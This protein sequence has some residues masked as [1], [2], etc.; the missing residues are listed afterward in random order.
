MKLHV[1]F[2][3]MLKEF[4]GRASDTL[5]VAEGARVADVLK[6][7]ESRI[8]RLTDMLPSLAVAVNQQYAGPQTV[9]KSEDEIALL[10]PVSG[11]TE[12]PGGSPPDGGV[13]GPMVRGDAGG[14]RRASIVWSRIDSESVSQAL[15][16]GEDGAAVVFEGTARNQTRGRKTLY[17][18]YEVYQ[19]MVLN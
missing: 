9:L 7:Y 4:T 12:D 16:A 14:N 2:F 18:D 3:G 8:P 19:H 13:R 17:L 6:H 1:L 15:K 10:P 11:G 5:D